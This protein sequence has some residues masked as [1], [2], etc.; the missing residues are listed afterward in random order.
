MEVFDA[1][2]EL[3]AGCPW[4]KLWTSDRDVLGSLLG[5]SKAGDDDG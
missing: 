1:Q 5:G 4:I 2:G 3:P